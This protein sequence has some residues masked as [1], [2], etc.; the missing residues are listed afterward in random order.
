LRKILLGKISQNTFGKS[1]AKYFWEKY[2]KILLG[3][4]SQNITPKPLRK[5]IAK[6]YTKTFN[7]NVL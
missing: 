6:H 3:K 2:R 7:K 5:S 4:V 1:I